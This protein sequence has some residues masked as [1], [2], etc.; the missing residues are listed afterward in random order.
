ML[1]GFEPLLSGWPQ[2]DYL[3]SRSLL[4]HSR[5]VGADAN[6]AYVTGWLEDFMNLG[7]ALGARCY[8]FTIC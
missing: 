2:A 3:T 7:E 8:M 6:R 4:L 5:S 1:R